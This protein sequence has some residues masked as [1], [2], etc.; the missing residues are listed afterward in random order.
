[1][2]ALALLTALAAAGCSDKPI[3]MNGNMT[4]RLDG[5]LNTALK[6]EGPMQIQMQVQGPVIRYEGTYISDE[7]LEQVQDGKTTDDWV[8]AVFGEPNARADLRDGTTIWRWT[9]KPIEQQASVVEVFSKSEKEPKRA[10]RTVFIQF[11]D[12]VAIKK[13]KG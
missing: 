6:L 13:W 3:T 5:Q 11:R 7:L 9:Y 8:L 4:G 10:T 1:M 2:T 12:A